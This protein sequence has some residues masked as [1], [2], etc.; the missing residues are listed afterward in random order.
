MGTL[1]K[2]QKPKRKRVLLIIIIVV[3]LI[4]AALAAWYF[5]VGKKQQDTKAKEQSD[6]QIMKAVDVGEKGNKDEAVQQLQKAADTTGDPGQKSKAYLYQANLLTGDSQLDSL[7]K[8]YQAD[9]SSQAA[10]YIAQRADEQGKKDIAIEYY[11]KAIDTKNEYSY[12]EAIEAY[13]KRI[14]E[15]QK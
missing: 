2:V 9:P 4:L 11:Q 13:K 3:V 5:L 10:S 12:D 7:I 15:L 6:S 14:A 1:I 8:A